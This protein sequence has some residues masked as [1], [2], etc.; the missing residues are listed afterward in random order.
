MQ[1]KIVTDFYITEMN[2]TTIFNL[3]LHSLKNTPI[4]IPPKKEQENIVKNINDG[5]SKINLAISKAQREIAA[6]KEY[7]E[8][9]ITDLVTGK[10]SIPQT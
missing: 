8:T 5:V 4:T 7:R 3:S 10:R 1:S 9:L 6:I 2:G